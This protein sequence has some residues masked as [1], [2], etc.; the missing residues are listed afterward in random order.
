VHLRQEAFEV[1]VV[2]PE[3]RRL[4]VRAEVH[5]DHTHRQW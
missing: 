2:D 3:W 4:G 1:V 5:K